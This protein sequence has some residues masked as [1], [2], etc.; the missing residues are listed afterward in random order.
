MDLI[1]LFPGDAHSAFWQLECEVVGE[2][3]DIDLRGSQINGS[4]GRRFIYLSW[5]VID[6]GEQFRMFRRAKLWLDAIPDDVLTA[7]IKAELLVGRLS[8]TDAKGLPLCASV[9]P[10]RIEWTTS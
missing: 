1:D 8:L 6:E 10:P 7:A 9:R 3:P 2:P 5:G 4:P